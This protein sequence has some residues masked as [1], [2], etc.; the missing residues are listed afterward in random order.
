MAYNPDPRLL[1]A[2]MRHAAPGD[3]AIALATTLV[4]S[5]GRLD[6]VGD[7]GQSFGP[8][9][10]YTGGRGAGIA[11]SQRQ[12]PVASTQRFL[13][14]L[15]TF[16]AKG[17]TGGEL[18]YATQR[19][20]DRAGY[21]TKINAALP[22][23]RQLLGGVA[24]GATAR[25]FRPA[26]GLSRPAG[27]PQVASPAGIRLTP[28]LQGRLQAYLQGSSDD[29]LAGRTPRDALPIV[30]A[31]AAA[32][33]RVAPAAAP[34][35][36]MDFQGRTTNRSAAPLAAGG[37]W[38]GSEAPAL[39]IA[40]ISGLPITSQKRDRQMTASGNVSDH[41]T[42]STNSYAVD[43]GTS[44]A[45]GD[46]AFKKIMAAL[47][48]PNLRPGQWYNLNIGGYRY[49]VGWRTPGHYDHIHVGVKKL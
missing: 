43:L 15:A 49:Q 42:G 22:V 27:T 13:R 19:P 6:A 38:G 10:E 8:Y 37:G 30:R 9:Q 26:P 20:A 35:P 36:V 18:A 4:E 47:G 17:L 23:A 7:N 24:G 40:K 16:R 28:A 48:Q 44:G 46:A 31:I 25:A 1:N 45:A 34:S 21:I 32:S 33:S 41:W 5:G 3:R 29:V 11:P 12:D 14:E 39:E 2:I